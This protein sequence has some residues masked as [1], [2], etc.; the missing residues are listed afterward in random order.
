[1]GGEENCFWYRWLAGA[2]GGLLVSDAW[3]MVVG[4]LGPGTVEDLSR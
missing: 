4:R 2:G 3:V 1:M